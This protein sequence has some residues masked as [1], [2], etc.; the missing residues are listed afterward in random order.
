MSI[1]PQP[2]LVAPQPPLVVA[3]LPLQAAVQADG[4]GGLCTCSRPTSEASRGRKPNGEGGACGVGSRERLSQKRAANDED[5]TTARQNLCAGAPKLPGRPGHGV[6][7][8]QS[9]SRANASPSA[10]RPKNQ[11]DYRI[12]ALSARNQLAGARSRRERAETT[13]SH[14]G[15]QPSASPRASTRTWREAPGRPERRRAKTYRLRMPRACEGSPLTRSGLPKKARGGRTSEPK[16]GLL[17]NEV[18]DVWPVSEPAVR[19]PF[20]PVWNTAASPQPH[21]RRRPLLLPRPPTSAPPP[22]PLIRRR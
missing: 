14:P 20:Y 11:K 5:S 18:A 9:Q 10:L 2:S 13:L 7:S 8:A 3:P 4:V 15:F 6:K 19:A 1:S 17:R 16:K 12:S 21:A 22:P